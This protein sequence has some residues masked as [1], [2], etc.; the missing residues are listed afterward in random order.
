L[1]RDWKTTTKD[2]TETSYEKA[3]PTLG[4]LFTTKI[5]GKPSCPV[6]RKELDGATGHGT[7]TPGDYT[8]CAYCG[9][10]LTF[11]DGIYGMDLRLLTDAEWSALPAEIKEQLQDYARLTGVV[12]RPTD[13]QM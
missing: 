10:F 5:K 8:V 9:A 11:T 2:V 3:G 12:W 1:G 7:P 6:C 13:R 4:K